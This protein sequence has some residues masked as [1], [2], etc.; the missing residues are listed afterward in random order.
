MPIGNRIRK[1][2]EFRGLTQKELGIRCGFNEDNAD[3]RIRQYENNSKVPRVDNL[4][5]ISEILEISSSVLM[6]NSIYEEFVENL[7]WAETEFGELDLFSFAVMNVQPKNAL[8]I[9]WKYDAKYNK[10]DSERWVS[11]VPIGLTINNI[12]INNFL[13]DW[14]KVKMKL[15]Q[16]EITEEEYF[17]WKINWPESSLKD[18]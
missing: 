13:R 2:R 6:P 8:E 18:R 7:L 15:V 10:Y 11:D 12:D 14:L 1:I 4:R 17:E 5:K 9:P 16:E 3:V